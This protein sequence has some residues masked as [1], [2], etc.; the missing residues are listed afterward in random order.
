MLAKRLPI[1]AYGQLLKLSHTFNVLDA[2]GA[3]SGMERPGN[4]ATMRGLARKVVGTNPH[5]QFSELH[6]FGLLPP[7]RP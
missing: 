5:Q 6:F 1:P 3:I 4:F 7:F 2:R